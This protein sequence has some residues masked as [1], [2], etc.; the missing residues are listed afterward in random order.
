MRRAIVAAAVL[1]AVL[2]AT[3]CSGSVSGEVSSKTAQKPVPAATVKVGDQQVV[4]DT[5]G[6]FVIDKVKTG[7]APVDVQAV[8]FGPH[9]ASLDVQRG[10]NTLNV[11]LEDG[12]V[13]VALKENAE[14]RESIKKAKVT[15]GGKSVS[16]AQG[17]RFTT[18]SVPVGEQTLV[19]TAPGHATVK[20]TITVV[21]GENN[22]KVAL[23]LTPVETYMRY[24]LAYRFNRL[25]EAYRMLHPDVRKHYSYKKFVSDMKSQITLGIKIFGAH[26]LTKWHPSYAHT[27]YH[28]VVAID[29]A[30]TYRDAYGTS[31]ENYTQHFQQI[32]GRWY[33]IWDWTE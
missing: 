32:N 25:Q 16:A 18:T 14:A 3:G 11:V 8:G 22:V 1:L 4:T 7:T 15:I 10:E 2:M 27:T 21:P 17:A 6:H 26:T 30:Y 12:T 20:K 24:Y 5:S 33:I 19:V 31:T 28:D 9:E 23:D 13:H 29:R